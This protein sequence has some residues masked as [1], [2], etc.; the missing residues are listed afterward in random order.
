MLVLSYD[1][2]EFTF[3]KFVDIQSVFDYCYFDI[4]KFKVANPR[5]GYHS[6]CRHPEYNI[7]FLF[8][9]SDNMGIHLSVAGHSIDYFFEHLKKY[10]DLSSKDD[11]ISYLLD[12]GKFTRIDTA[13]DDIG[14]EYYSVNQILKDLKKNRYVT[15]ASVFSTIQSYGT[16]DND[17]KGNTIYIGRRISEVMLRIYDKKLE[18][19]FKLPD[20]EPLEDHITRWELEVKHDSA[21]LYAEKISEKVNQGFEDGL[22]ISYYETLSSFFRLI[23]LDN[24]RKTRCSIQKKYLEFCQ[25]IKSASL[26]RSK[27]ILT[28]DEKMAYTFTMCSKNLALCEMAQDGFTDM[29]LDYGSSL[30]CANDLALI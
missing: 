13:C 6:A 11:M 18:H 26:G 8:N 22:K 12:V 7:I 20:E 23:N 1:W 3:K 10:I 16:D 27:K 24:E 21:Q 14:E 17:I 29:C 9:G 25:H 5:Y 15:R 28:I 2:L 30:L 19:D 4:S